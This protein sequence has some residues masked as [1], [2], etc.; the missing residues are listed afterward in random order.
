MTPQTVEAL[1]LLRMQACFFTGHRRLLSPALQKQAG[2]FLMTLRECL[3][4]EIETLCYLGVTVF[5]CGG[6]RGFDLLAGA[7]VLRLRA[8]HPELRLIVLMPCRDQTRGWSGEERALYEEVL[9]RAEVYCLQESYDS[10]CMRRRNRM[11]VDLS[12]VGITCYEPESARSGT[13]MTVRYAQSCGIPLVSLRSICLAQME[14]F[15]LD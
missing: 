1:S 10:E 14:A 13:G 11:L 7:A 2:A 4:R 6:A 3:D 8:V 15:S 12:A 9:S 5:Y